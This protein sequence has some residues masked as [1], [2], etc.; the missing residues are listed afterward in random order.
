MPDELTERV[1]A[2]M[3]ATQHLPAENISI[4]NTFQ[5]LN[6]DSLDGINIVFALEKEFDIDIPDESAQKIRTVREMVDGVRS[7]LAA[8]GG[9]SAVSG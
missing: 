1:I 8:K 3:A 7:L 2:V 6:F 4:D 9:A 5:E